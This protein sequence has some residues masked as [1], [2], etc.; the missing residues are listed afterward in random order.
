MFTLHNTELSSQEMESEL[1]H[2][3]RS[4]FSQYFNDRKTG[5]LE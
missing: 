3:E 2:Q 1:K 4:T 5:K